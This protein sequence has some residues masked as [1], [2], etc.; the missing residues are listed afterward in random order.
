MIS[1]RTILQGGAAFGAVTMLAPGFAL[2]RANTGKRF[3]L[4]VLRG[5]VD[6]LSFV[7]PLGDPD[8]QRLRGRWLDGPEA[9]IKLDSTFALHPALKNVGKLYG[10]GDALLAHAIATDYRDRSHFDAQNLLETGGNRPF[11]LRDGWLNRFLGLVEGGKPWA[12]AIAP[13]IPLALRGANPVTNYAPTALPEASAETIE[14]IAALYAQDPALHAAWSASQGVQEQVGESAMTGMR[15][16]ARAGDLA[17]RLMREE[18]G[19]RIAMLDL[20]GWDSHANQVGQLN[21]RFGELD[22][23]LGAFRQ[24]IGPLWSETAVLV[25]TEFGRTVAINGTNGTDHGTGGAAMLLGGEVRGKRV[26]ADWPGLAAGG[27]LEGRDLKPT[28]STEAFIA[29]ALAEHYALEPARVMEAL[30]P[31]RQQR[32]MTGLIAT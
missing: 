25:L 10:G 30:F 5:A 18:N 22:S 4:V 2:A 24:G 11:Q 23:M 21:R 26:V 14:R 32:P 9:E 31:G 20:P 15:D 17:A 28:G 19:A 16:A 7:P 13:S 6:G 3:F 12:L 1:R 8:F 27:L 29:G